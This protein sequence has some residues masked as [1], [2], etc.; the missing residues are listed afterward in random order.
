MPSTKFT[1]RQPLKISKDMIKR[2]LIH[3]YVGPFQ[4]FY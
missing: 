4:Y 2:L 1:H 3:L